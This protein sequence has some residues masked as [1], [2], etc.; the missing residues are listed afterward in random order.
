MQKQK[1]IRNPKHTRWIATL[2]CCLAGRDIP[3]GGDVVAAH[4]RMGSGAGMGQKPDDN[5]TVPLCHAHHNFQ[6][7]KG[8]LFFWG[9]HL[10]DAK[11]LAN[12]LYGAS[13]QDA[14]RY[15]MDFNAITG[16]N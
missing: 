6:H 16:R 8:E 14:Y 11:K 9:Q 5:L 10:N 12:M 2:P 15:I 13:L 7:T 4:I 1:K 3:C